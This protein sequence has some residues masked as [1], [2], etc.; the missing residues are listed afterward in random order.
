VI[1]ARGKPTRHVLCL[2]RCREH[3]DLGPAECLALSQRST[4]LDPGPIRQ[5]DVEENEIGL[6]E[7]RERQGPFAVERLEDPNPLVLK[8]HPNQFDN[9]WLVVG[10]QDRV[11]AASGAQ[12]ECQP[13]RTK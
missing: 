7:R 5:V 10:D 4:N 9:R 12:A 8:R 2:S 3:D 11:H 13:E 1:G 6:K